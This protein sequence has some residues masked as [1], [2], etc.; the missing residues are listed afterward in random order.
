MV[1][2]LREG[3]MTEPNHSPGRPRASWAGVLGRIVAATVFAAAFYLV[4]WITVF[5]AVTSALAASGLGV[6]LVAGSAASD[7]VA[8]VLDAI[9]EM[10][11]AVLGAIAAG[12]GAIFS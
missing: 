8:A 7:A 4:L 5:D 10:L 9:G 11:A 1:R 12:V 2:V 3:P 6:V